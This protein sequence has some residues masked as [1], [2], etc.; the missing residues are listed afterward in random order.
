VLL[1]AGLGDPVEAWQ[2]QLDQLADRYRM[3]AFDNRGSGRSPLHPGDR[4]SVPSM[5]DDAAAVLRAQGVGAAHVAGFSGGSIIAQELALR[6]PE[7]VRSLVLVSTWAEPDGYLRAVLGSWR[8]MIAAA[9]SE[10]AFLE[11][12]FVWIYTARAHADGA[13]AQM[14][15]EALAFPHNA[16][17]ESF[18]PAID[19]LV[20]HRT[21]DRLPRIEVAAFLCE[22]ALLV[23]LV[24]AGARTVPARPQVV[25]LQTWCTACICFTQITRAARASSPGSDRCG[26]PMIVHR[27]T[28]TAA[29]ALLDGPGGGHLLRDHLHYAFFVGAGYGVLPWARASVSF[30]MRRVRVSGRTAVWMR[31]R[32]A[33][34]LRP[35]SAA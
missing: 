31:F 23:V 20:A 15:E 13:V 14:V 32:K 34:R 1:I 11:A 22:L 35:S 5:A 3:T 6:H 17:V 26:C 8:W 2:F 16:S 9:P 25:R 33:K 27:V 10:R 19:A 29:C 7:L 21:A 30:S 12:F 4:F 28:H 18:Q 24:V